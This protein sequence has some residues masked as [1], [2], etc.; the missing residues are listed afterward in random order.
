MHCAGYAHCVYQTYMN[1]STVHSIVLITLAAL[2]SVAL[3]AVVA[4][5]VSSVAAV[6]VATSAAVRPPV[7]G[8]ENNNNKQQ[9]KLIHAQ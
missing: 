8:C 2:L 9:E 3:S 7:F 6:A 4:M 1:C 5:S